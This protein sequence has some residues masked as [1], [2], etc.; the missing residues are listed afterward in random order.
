MHWYTYHAFDDFRK[1]YQAE[2]D[3]PPYVSPYMQTR[4]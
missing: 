3:T 2:F 4:W 1:D